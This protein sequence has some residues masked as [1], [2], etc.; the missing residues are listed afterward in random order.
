MD[1]AIQ[2]QDLR[3]RYGDTIAADGV[4][5]TVAA[6][7]I[8]GLLGPNGAGKT[9]TVECLIGLRQPDAGQVRLLGMEYAG[10]SQAIRARLGLHGVPDWKVFQRLRE[11]KNKA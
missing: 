9:T 10:Q 8:F 1:T 2:V 7:E 6:G 5:F 4:T 11:L 3:K